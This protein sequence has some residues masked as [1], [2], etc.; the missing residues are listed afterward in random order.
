MKTFAITSGAVAVLA[1]A[2]MGSSAAANAAPTGSESASDVLLFPA[3]DH[4]F[5]IHPD[6]SV[7]AWSRMLNWFDAHLR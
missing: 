6:G 1:A 7:E 3:A 4:R 2:V 5:D